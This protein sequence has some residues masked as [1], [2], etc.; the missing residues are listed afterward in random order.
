MLI[1]KRCW[2]VLLQVNV[3]AVPK[4]TKKT[5][6]ARNAKEGAGKVLREEGLGRRVLG[7]GSESELG[8]HDQVIPRRITCRDVCKYVYEY[9]TG[10]CLLFVVLLVLPLLL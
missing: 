8:P 2:R 6:K 3:S 9:Y 4:N 7:G 10:H 5:K 1:L